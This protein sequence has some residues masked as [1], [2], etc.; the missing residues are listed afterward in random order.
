MNKWIVTLLTLALMASLCA[1]YAAAAD[2]PGEENAAA[3]AEGEAAP[4]E[5][6]DIE[7]LDRI[8]EETEE[9]YK[10]ILTNGTGAA[11]VGLNIQKTTDAAW[12][13]SGEL[14]ADGDSFE[15]GETALFCCAPGEGEDEQTAYNLQVAFDDETV[16]YLHYVLPSDME[17]AALGRTDEG[18]LCLTYESLATGEQ[19]DTAEAEQKLFQGD[20]DMTLWDAVLHGSGAADSAAETVSG[21]ANTEGC[22]GGDALFN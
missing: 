19:I 3:D 18:V 2:A 22:V 11:I 20:T 15:D 16:G 1:G 13:W 6:V 9:G 7:K 17:R 14:L 4:L 10:I 12:T 5:E 8:G 21:G